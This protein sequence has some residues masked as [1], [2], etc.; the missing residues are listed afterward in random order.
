MPHKQCFFKFN[1]IFF[2]LCLSPV[3]LFRWL[4]GNVIEILRDVLLLMPLPYKVLDDFCKV[5]SPDPINLICFFTGHFTNRGAI[6]GLL[7]HQGQFFI[8]LIQ[9]LFHVRMIRYTWHCYNWYKSLEPRRE[10][11]RSLVEV[12]MKLIPANEQL[13]ILSAILLRQ[14]QLTAVLESVC[15]GKQMHISYE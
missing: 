11:K 6:N 5:S 13:N 12:W 10:N 14:H 3:S 4:R 15:F 9:E 7:F 8:Q 2:L 1:P